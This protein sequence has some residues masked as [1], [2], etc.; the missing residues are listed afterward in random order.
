MH[1]FAPSLWNKVFSGGIETPVAFSNPKLN[2]RKK[3]G[4]REGKQVN[5]PNH[6]KTYHHTEQW[7]HHKEENDE[8]SFSKQACTHNK[9]ITNILEVLWSMFSGPTQNSLAPTRQTTRQNSSTPVA[10]SR[11]Y[12]YPTGIPSCPE[13]HY[14]S[15]AGSKYMVFNLP[16]RRE[17]PLPKLFTRASTNPERHIQKSILVSW[18]KWY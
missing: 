14:T 18:K 8:C 6:F 2:C 5:K 17:P 10:Y 4:M 9:H 15:M 13:K 16:W 11:L 12:Q 1:T 7:E 3:P